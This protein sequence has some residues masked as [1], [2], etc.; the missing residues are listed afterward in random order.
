MLENARFEGETDVEED[1]AD[2]DASEDT[3]AG[4]AM[5]DLALGPKLRLLS[6]FS[7]HEK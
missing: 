5:V 3:V 7:A 4:Y 1:L 2:F 6:G